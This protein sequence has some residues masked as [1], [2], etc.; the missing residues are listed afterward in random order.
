MRGTDCSSCVYSVVNSIEWKVESPGMLCSG[1]L[2]MRG[3]SFDFKVV[4]VRQVVVDLCCLI[5][6]F[7]CG[8]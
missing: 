6:E 3:C 1:W 4:R 8:C 7:R 5:A 2:E